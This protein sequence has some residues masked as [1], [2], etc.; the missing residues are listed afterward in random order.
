MLCYVCEKEHSYINEH[1][2]IPQARGGKNGPKILLCS[3]CHQESHA[4]ALGK[5][6]LESI[7]NIR[8]RKV[9]QLLRISLQLPHAEIYKMT[10]SMPKDIYLFIRQEALDNKR[11]MQTIIN[12]ILNKFKIGKGR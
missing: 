6:T 3:I 5:C 7:E 1:H 8:L 2:I 10:L 9:V 12:S 11:S 4:L